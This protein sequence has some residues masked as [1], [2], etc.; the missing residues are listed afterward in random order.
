VRL[1]PLL[2]LVAPLAFAAPEKSCEEECADDTKKCVDIC[3]T[4][5]P[6]RARPHCKTAC[7][8]GEKHC[9]AQC[10]EKK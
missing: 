10:K 6:V 8:E 5:A 2:M 3:T 9:R 7:S 1:L 4:R